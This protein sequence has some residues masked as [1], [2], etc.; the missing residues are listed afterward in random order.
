MNTEALVAGFLFGIF[1]IVFFSITRLEYSRFTYPLVLVSLPLFYMLFAVYGDN[2]EVWYKELLLGVPFF[3]IAWIAIFSVRQRAFLWLA[4]G[5]IGHAVFDGFHDQ[6][7]QNPGVPSWW[8][9]V[10]IGSD[11][12]LA[13]FSL[14]EAF[15]KKTA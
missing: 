11:G 1:I 15:S 2:M 9:E 6:L 7:L 12:M 5:F 13:L 14:T 3:I 8:L 10:C 4:L